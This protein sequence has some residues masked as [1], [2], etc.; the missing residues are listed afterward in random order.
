M[1]AQMT[2]DQPAALQAFSAMGFEREALLR[3]Q[4]MD[5]AGELHDLVIMGLDVDVFQASREAARLMAEASTR[6]I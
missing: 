5:R 2:A 3:G 6:E 1:V 4:V